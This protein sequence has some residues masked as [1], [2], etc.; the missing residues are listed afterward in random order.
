MI[1]EEQGSMKVQVLSIIEYDELGRNWEAKK[2]FSPV[3]SD[4]ERAIERMERYRY[5]I[6]DLH[7]DATA[8]L[9][10]LS[11]CGGNDLFV[12]DFT[13]QDEQGQL[14]NRLYYDPARGDDFLDVWESD[15][16]LEIEAHHVCDL[17]T[18]LTLARRFFETGEWD[19]AIPS[20]LRY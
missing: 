18:I 19:E 3:W 15:Q 14:H 4:V 6:V 12:P 20:L 13:C 8:E 16:G 9:P 1:Q 2:I 11:V 5:P 7:L 17:P 10:W